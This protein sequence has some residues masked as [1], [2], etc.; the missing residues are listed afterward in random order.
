MFYSVLI[1]CCR[2]F[3]R[4]KLPCV[5]YLAKFTLAN[6]PENRCSYFSCFCDKNTPL[7]PLC[8][9]CALNTAET[10]YYSYFPSLH[11]R[12]LIQVLSQLFSGTSSILSA[13]Q[14][15]MLGLCTLFLS[16][17]VNKWPSLIW[18]LG[19]EGGTLP[20]HFYTDMLTHVPPPH[21]RCF[22]R[23]KQWRMKRLAALLLV[24]SL[25]F[26]VQS[27]E[28]PSL[29]KEYYDTPDGYFFK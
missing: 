7:R 1:P 8:I 22:K 24:S 27:G 13:P 11:Q 21:F 3:K 15:P 26:Y 12:W 19:G 29:R 20:V 18:R 17:S 4:R 28:P 16:L 14:H 2:Y 10:G 23:L 5:I 9:Y 6:C 25:L